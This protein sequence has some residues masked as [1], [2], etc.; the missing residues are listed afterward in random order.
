MTLKRTQMEIIYIA[1][2][3]NFVFS[4]S[5]ILYLHYCGK[6]FMVYIQGGSQMR[7]ITKNTVFAAGKGGINTY[8]IPAVINADGVLLAFCEGR[9]ENRGDSGNICIVVKRSTDR[10][11]SWSPYTVV[12]GDDKNSYGNCNPVVDRNTGRIHTLCNYNDGN[13]SEEDIRAGKGIRKCY[14]M[15]SDDNG[16][17]WSKPRDI[18][19]YVN[20]PEWSW[21]AIGPCHGIQT[22][23]GRFVFGG[24]HAYLSH[25]TTHENYDGYSFSMYSDDDCETFNVSPDVSPETNECSI[26]Q[27]PDGRLYINM[28]SQQHNNRFAAYSYDEGASWTDFRADKTLIDPHCQG[29]V[30]AVSDKLYFCNT[31]SLTRDTLT[32]S[33]STDNGGTWSEKLLIHKGPAAYSDLV[34]IDEK[35]I[36]CLYEYGEAEHPYENIGF[37][38]IEI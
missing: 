14:H 11:I 7:F 18:T 27:L 16:E 25:A 10:G 34:Q 28:R 26:A 3:I 5:V 1:G 17:T 2:F 32:L 36:G 19:S 29:S 4:M 31:A 12:F 13:V 8:R 30:L 6:L 22:R 20:K 38:I 24:N 35:T 37:A 23:S 21:H 9:K 33:L 15:Y